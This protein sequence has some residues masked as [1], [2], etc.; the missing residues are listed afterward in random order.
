VY[1]FQG[2][3]YAEEQTMRN[4]C[5]IFTILLVVV[6]IVSQYRSAYAFVATPLLVPFPTS[7]SLY[8]AKVVKKIN[9][10]VLSARTSTT[11]LSVA[12]IHARKV[13]IAHSSNNAVRGKLL[14]I[15]SKF[16]VSPGVYY[17]VLQ[18]ILAQTF[19]P[20][21]A[22]IATMVNAIP[23]FQW[24]FL[25]QW[26]FQDK[27]PVIVIDKEEASSDD[28]DNQEREEYKKAC[29]QAFPDSNTY[30]FA[31]VIQRVGLLQMIM[32]LSDVFLVFLK[33]MDFKFVVKYQAQQAAAS[34]VFSSWMAY[35]LSRLK[36]Y[37]LKRGSFLSLKNLRE[38]KKEE[39]E[40]IEQ[41]QQIIIGDDVANSAG[42]PAA[43]DDA[44]LANK[45]EA[46]MMGLYNRFA[47]RVL[48]V[49]IY[50]CAAISVVDLLG[51]HIGFALKSV[52][53]L[54][55][56]GT[57][58]LSLASKDVAAEFVGGLMIQSSSFFYEGESVVL[59]DGTS[60]KVLKIGWLHTYIQKAD[61]FLVRVPNSQISHQRIAREKRKPQHNQR[62]F[63]N[64]YM[65]KS[66]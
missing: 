25:R 21:V 28:A 29:L 40:R 17:Q 63:K 64:K 44:K 48:D 11:A 36:H 7:K 33:L 47:N 1:Y 5:S 27:S 4:K 39:E 57:L 22:L 42:T 49:I 3:E 13:Q 23:I 32:Y 14:L 56:F 46:Q 52:F 54:G 55:S 38:M 53:G 66:K 8:T 26:W 2:P 31:L 62:K 60:G 34:I 12:A 59:Q 65:Y 50:G 16:L 30:K 6:G 19:W 41:E 18:R 43:T 35:N 15:V 20:E 10:V 24:F 45:N 37:Y 58:V 9:D 61:D 51:V